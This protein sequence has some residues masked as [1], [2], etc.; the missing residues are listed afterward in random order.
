MLEGV[1]FQGW[2]EVAKFDLESF[3]LVSSDSRM[4]ARSESR[5]EVVSGC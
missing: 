4:T 5:L 2:L 3:G 1:L